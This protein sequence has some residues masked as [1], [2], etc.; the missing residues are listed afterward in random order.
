[1]VRS[2]AANSVGHSGCFLTLKSVPVSGLKLDQERLTVN[3]IMIFV[4]TDLFYHLFTFVLMWFC[5][6]SFFCTKNS[7]DEAEHRSSG[8]FSESYFIISP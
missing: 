2:I 3:I 4:L 1:M 6:G 8:K 7:C 5:S